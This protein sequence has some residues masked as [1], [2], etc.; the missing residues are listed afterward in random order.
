MRLLDRIFNDKNIY[1]LVLF[2][3][4]SYQKILVFSFLTTLISI[5]FVLRIDVLSNLIDLLPDDT[6]SI[7]NLEAVIEKTGGF[8]NLMVMIES[9]DLSRSIDYAD[10]LS[11][12]IER[13]QWVSFVQYKRDV[14]VFK[15]N[16][17]LYI[18][19]KDLKAI[20][21]R[22][23]YRIAYEKVYR[24][25][26]LFGLI[27]KPPPKLDFSDIEARYKNSEDALEYFQSK[28]GQ[29]LILVVYPN[30]VTSNISFARRIYN[31]IVALV[32]KDE[33]QQAHLDMKVSVGG[34]FKNRIDEFDT[35]IQDVK[36]SGFWAGLGIFLL[37]T[38]YFRN[39]LSFFFICFP[40]A[41]GIVFTFALIYLIIGNLNLI[42]VFLF[43]V[44]FGLGIDFGIHML[45]R[46]FEERRA[47]T[48][49][50]SS[51]TVVLSKTGRASLTAALTTT[52]AF[53]SLTVT[54]FKGFSEFGFIAGTGILFSLISFFTIFPSLLI[55]SEKIGILHSFGKPNR[56]PIGISSRFTFIILLVGGMITIGAI[57]LLPKAQF[58][59][60]LR[61]L[62]SEMKESRE[63]KN[64]MHKVFT[65]PQDAAIV[66]VNN[67]DEAKEV[68]DA[69]SKRISDNQSSIVKGVRS[70]NCLIPAEQEQKLAIIDKLKNT[71]HSD[72]I[73]YIP[74]E[75]MEKVEELRRYVDVS[76]I[77]INDIPES[78]QR[79][80]RGLPGTFGQLVYIFQSRSLLD[81][82]NA[83][84]FSK[85]IREIVTANKTYYAASEPL[86]F[87]DMLSILKRD[88]KI[89]F[90]VTFF[91]I[92]LFLLF[93]L[94]SIKSTCITLSPL[95]LGIIWLIAIMV[96][97]DIRFNLFN[98]LVFPVIIGLGIDNSVH[99]FHRYH[100]NSKSHLSLALRETKGALAI[101]T[102][103]SMIGFGGMLSAEHPG[104]HSI[105]LL[106]VIGLGM[107]LI[108]SLT[109]LP[110]ILAY[111]TRRDSTHLNVMEKGF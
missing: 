58:E 80:F 47:G 82:R 88:S 74:K 10:R 29:I 106:A 79:P 98:M 86:V 63:F 33:L 31:E 30:G 93:D 6:K 84:E 48:D 1:G 7:K 96:C 4:S 41:I 110:A 22:I 87:A 90:F 34:T 8:G 73:K 76:A 81:L 59:Y 35:V 111:L 11:E 36:T 89:A 83:L 71:L 107:C 40:L 43:V 53:Y 99:M 60:D 68:Q 104:L 103:T 12:K 101:T 42:T 95:I 108:A 102:G 39:I 13:L 24:N 62:R 52:V 57:V 45:S 97:F 75:A 78:L 66:L 16:R 19:L 55:F 32:S 61:K 64:K 70:L 46:Y 27:R 44:L 26:L 37:I 14:E 67:I 100:E 25:P 50:I 17:I 109:V 23:D 72:F 105:G 5:I 85:E 20:K 15:K 38:L 18:Q 54:D 28:D 51:L 91:M 92:S 21:S 65:D 56:I 69:V 77:T 49:L 2:I 3:L 94:R 9:S